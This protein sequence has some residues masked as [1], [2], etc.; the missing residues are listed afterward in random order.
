MDFAR[1]QNDLRAQRRA[2]RVLG[3]IV[4]VL[5]LTVLLCL[6][7][8][9]SIA[10]SERTVIVPPNIDR[11]F[12][13]TKE[14]ASREYLEQMGAYVAW[15]VLDVTPTTVD[16][17]R[18]LLLNWVSPDR[19]A[20]LKNRMDLEAERLRS[21]N[22]ST[23]FLVQ[24]LVADENRQSVVVTGRLRRQI[25]GVDVAEPE[26]RSYLAQFGF[27]GGRIHIHSFKEVANAPIGQ[28]AGA[29][30]APADVT[31]SR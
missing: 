2:N 18:N 4:G 12:W 9:V 14:K 25:N 29:G 6:A 7:V 20:E 23:F 15:L 31:A 13:V 19:H 24:Q 8:I 11:T 3:S 1:H 27:A 16:W 30:N 17:K 28:P 26:T 10:G 5:S 22:A 21:N